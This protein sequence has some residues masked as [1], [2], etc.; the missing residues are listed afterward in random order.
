MGVRVNKR[1]KLEAAQCGHTITGAH[2]AQ[3]SDT[4]E[5]NISTILQINM[6]IGKDWK[7]RRRYTSKE[8]RTK[9]EGESYLQYKSIEL[10]CKAEIEMLMRSSSTSA[11]TFRE[12]DEFDASFTNTPFRQYLQL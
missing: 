7:E 5:S 9:E 4:N 12:E 11:K 10:K 6:S 1:Y 8:K 2:V 3:N